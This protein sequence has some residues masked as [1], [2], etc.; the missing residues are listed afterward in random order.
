MDFPSF[1]QIRPVCLPAEDDPDLDRYNGMTATASGWGLL[2]SA[3]ETMSQDLMEVDLIIEDQVS[4]GYSWGGGVRI[5]ARP[6]CCWKP[7]DEEQR[8]FADYEKHDLRK[9]TRKGVC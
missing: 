7:A 2:N 3:E 5:Q 4:C 6:I 1:P 9:Q 8:P